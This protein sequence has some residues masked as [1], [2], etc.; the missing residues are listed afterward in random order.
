MNLEDSLII[1]RFY[2]LLTIVLDN[3]G[4]CIKTNPLLTL[5][6]DTIINHRTLDITIELLNGGVLRFYEEY[7]YQ[8]YK[9]RVKYH[10]LYL[11][12]NQESI[13][14]CDNSPHHPEVSTFPHHKHYYPK[15]SYKPIAFSG[16]L[17]D[18]LE[19]VKRGILS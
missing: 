3:L 6:S 7:E 19:E 17:I 1:I 10:Y 9:L 2:H 18:F 16:E 8:D 11:D 13:L 14:S 12:S 4:T 5:D 15:E